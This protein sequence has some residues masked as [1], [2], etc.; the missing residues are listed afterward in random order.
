MW[1]QYWLECVQLYVTE[2]SSYPYWKLSLF[3]KFQS[4]ASSSRLP[5]GCCT[6]IH[7]A[8]IPRRNNEKKARGKINTSN[9]SARKTM[10]FLESQPKYLHNYFNFSN[11]F[12]QPFLDSKGVWEEAGYVNWIYCYSEQKS[13]FFYLESEAGELIF[14]RQLVE[15]Q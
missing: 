6:C 9:K 7:H 8:Y 5:N 1:Q 4:V 10:A 14:G 11:W 2:I 13:G 15:S 3:S 12:I